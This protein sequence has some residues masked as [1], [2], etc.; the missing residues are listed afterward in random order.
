[1]S[2][3]GPD[4]DPVRVSVIIQKLPPPIPLLKVFD[5]YAKLDKVLAVFYEALRLFR[6]S[7]PF[8]LLF[9]KLSI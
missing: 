8:T 9:L 7:T 6:S 2:V 4:R 3:V 1:M 5:D